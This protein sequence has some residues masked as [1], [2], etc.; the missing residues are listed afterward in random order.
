[1]KKLVVVGIIVL[2]VGASVVPLTGMEEKPTIGRAIL[3]V[4]GSGP[5]N[6]SKIQYA[7]DNASNG[8][9]VFVYN[10]TYYENV[11][12]DKSINLT[13][14]DRNNTIIDGGGSGE[15][16]YVS[17][18]W[19]SISNFTIKNSGS[20]WGDAGIYILGYSNNIISGNKIIS[21][22]E[23]ILFFEASKNIVKGNN[24]SSNGGCGIYIEL[25]GNNIIFGND[26]NSNE[27]GIVFW[28]SQNNITGNNL[29]YNNWIGIYIVYDH[30]SIIRDNNISSNNGD[31]ICFTESNSHDII[32]NIISLNNGYGIHL[33]ISSSN[34]IISNAISSNNEDGIFLDYYGN[35][36][37]IYHNNFI[38]NTQNAYDECNN[39]W[40]SATHQEGNYWDDYTGEDDDGDGIGDTPYNVPG[41]SNQ[42]LYPLMN[43]FGPPYAE[44]NFVVDSGIVEFNASLSGDYEGYIE[45]Y[46]WDFGDGSIGGGMIISHAYSLSGTYDVKLT[47]TDDDGYEDNITK[48]IE[49]EVPNQPPGA[50]LING[51]KNGKAGKLYPYTFVSKDPEGHNVS[52][53][54]N[55]GDGDI[56]LSGFYESNV[57]I[58]IEH[59]WD[60]KGSY[61]IRTRAID[62]YGEIGNWSPPFPISMPKNKPF[63]YNSPLL[64]WLFERF[65]NMFPLL[66]QLI[67]QLNQTKP[68]PLLFFFLIPV[69]IICVN[70]I[71]VKPSSI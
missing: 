34:T 4:G 62:E 48:S 55:W 8:D 59:E 64:N 26:I 66:R 32:G 20:N 60:E 3:Y 41:G 23:G 29:C 46:D 45:S 67:G 15:V 43:I 44:F 10:G 7:I 9:T 36:N 21:N 61:E 18:D 69:E 33:D 28:D 42:D 12:V 53:E 25:G 30:T 24:I 70:E 38:N 40:Y 13:G 6:Y 50:P 5:G 22:N 35:N 71:S 65:P 2:F 14:E 58:T 57:I 17:A 63:F 39:T 49:V 1:M 51:P 47:V 56:N 27:E 68:I 31:G 54:I 16:V 19:A 52:Y 37:I 11:G